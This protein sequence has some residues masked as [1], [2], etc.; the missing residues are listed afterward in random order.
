MSIFGNDKQPELN[1]D[2]KAIQAFTQFF[3]SLD[4][5]SEDTIRFFERKAS[6]YSNVYSTHGNDAHTIAEEVFKS[7][8]QIKYLDKAAAK[9]NEES[10]NAYLCFNSSLF[11]QVAKV[12]LFKL[13][14]TVELY[15]TRRDKPGAWELKKKAEPGNSHSLDELL[16]GTDEDA[17]SELVI[18]VKLGLEHG[19]RMVGIAYMD[20]AK[21]SFVLAEF[22][23]NEQFTNLESVVVQVGAKKCLAYIDPK[24][25][26]HKKI[27]DILTRG[28][29]ALINKKRADFNTDDVE[30][31]LKRLLTNL[32]SHINQLDK[33]WA[34]GALACL[35]K[36]LELLSDDKNYGKYKMSDFNLDKY[37]KLD[38]AALRALNLLPQATD[39]NK[40][41]SVYGLLNKCKTAIGSRLLMQWIRQPLIDYDQ[42]VRRHDIVEGLIGDAITRQGLQENC[43]NKAP[44]LERIVKKLQRGKAKL[45]DCVKIYQFLLRLPT[46]IDTLDNF[47][48]QKKFVDII[49]KS[50]KTPLEDLQKDFAN[51]M[52]LIE[53]T[54]DL[55]EIDNHEYFINPAFDEQLQELKERRDEIQADIDG[56]LQDV[57]DDLG[58]DQEK[59]QLVQD[60]RRH[61]FRVPSKGYEHLI[62]NNKK[63]T[64][65]EI[66]KQACKFTNSKLEELSKEFKRVND[67]YENKQSDLVEK[68]LSIVGML[69]RDLII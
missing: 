57:A 65:I 28:D 63:Y 48:G 24:D 6:A 53:N 44:D 61:A 40:N 43:L 5:K 30:Q 68:T 16:A 59:L 67:E 2:K 33:R 9:N 31:D 69:K 3:S 26:D 51:L 56:L 1:L 32:Q 25:Y 7:S 42:I 12:L 38:T 29:V 27:S 41:Y 64:T 49:K 45:E 62:R 17:D 36:H 39:A 19:Q 47:N 46:F 10:P 18:S 8:E 14:K 58:I 50:Y 52:T 20:A 23:D 55:S 34:I 4:E 60:N 35:L 11:E 66:K 15:A 22:A 54:V 37:M 21:S 13:N